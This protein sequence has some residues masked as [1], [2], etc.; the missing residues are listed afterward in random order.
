MKLMAA[1][2]SSIP[3]DMAAN[4]RKH[5][6][7]VELAGSQRADAVF[8]PELSLTGYEPHLAQAL[9]I[10]AGDERLDVFQRL[11]DRL[12]LLI[13]VGVPTRGERGNEISMI[14]FQPGVPRSTYSKQLLHADELPFF[15]PGVG[16]RVF[17]CADQVLAPAICYESLQLQHAQQAADAGA[18][19]YCASV[20][21]SARGVGAAYGHYPRIAKQH[22]LTV[23]MA[24]CVGPADNFVSAGQSG[25][26]DADGQLIIGADAAGEALVSYEL[27]TGKGALLSLSG[28]V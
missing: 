16:T 5:V 14:T 26:W 28:K 17:A 24:N 7:V 6:A 15:S 13:A 9:A 3:G 21:K 19:V 18:H 12:N 1:Q 8:F 10:G 20:A 23:M 2:I 22:A 25:F 27:G 4:I 11:S